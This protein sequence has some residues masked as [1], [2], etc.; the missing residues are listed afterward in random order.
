MP[1]K[2]HGSPRP[3]R[4]R[5]AACPPARRG[6]I[7]R[8]PSERSPRPWNAAR[9]HRRVRARRG[10][11]QSAGQEL[12]QK[13]RARANE[14]TVP[15]LQEAA[16]AQQPRLRHRPP[17]A[18]GSSVSST[19]TRRGT[20]SF[21]ISS[22]RG[23][24][25]TACRARFSPAHHVLRLRIRT[26]ACVCAGRIQG[27]ARRA[28]LNARANPPPGSFPSASRSPSRCASPGLAMACATPHGIF[29]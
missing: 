5:D 29:V 17:P 13:R 15:P 27:A 19:P 24:V 28:C 11:A 18:S 8:E 10:T 12:D 25:Q 7:S 26:N 23:L 20:L 14:S 22:K 3:A 1:P 6:T 21:A 9:P 4:G 2:S 16:C